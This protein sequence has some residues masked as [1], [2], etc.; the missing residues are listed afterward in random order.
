MLPQIHLNYKFKN[1]T[2]KN[3]KIH[4]LSDCLAHGVQ[5]LNGMKC[6]PF[7]TWNSEI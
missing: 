6:I 5:V 3:V 4:G 2:F 7:D 1:I